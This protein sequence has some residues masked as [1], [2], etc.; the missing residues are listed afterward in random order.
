MF[1]NRISE[2]VKNILQQLASLH[3]TQAYVVL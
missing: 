3:S 2:L 1:V